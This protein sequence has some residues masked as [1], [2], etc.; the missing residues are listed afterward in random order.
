MVTHVQLIKRA[1]K[2]GY[3]VTPTL[4]AEL[5]VLASVSDE[6]IFRQA[7]REWVRGVAKDFQVP[8]AVAEARLGNT[9]PFQTQRRE[10]SGE[11]RD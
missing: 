1:E 5:L 10:A 8:V 6:T 3:E 2:M 4:S 9:G 7:R 11:H